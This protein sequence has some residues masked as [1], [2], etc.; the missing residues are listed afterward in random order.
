MCHP[1]FVDSTLESLDPLTTLREH[2]F[3]FFNSDTFLE[4][5]AAHGV[6]L[7]QPTGE[8]GQAS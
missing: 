8:S 3:A 6:E 7:A 1:G 2:E 4:V 5:L